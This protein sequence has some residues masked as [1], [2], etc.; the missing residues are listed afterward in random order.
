VP[1]SPEPMSDDD[2][3]PL[4]SALPPMSSVLDSPG[5]TALREAIGDAPAKERAR[6]VIDALR[7]ELSRGGAPADRASLLARASDAL[8]A[9]AARGSQRRLRPVLNATGVVLHTNLGR[10]PLSDAVLDEVRAASTGAC[11]LEFD[12]ER[13]AR[14]RRDDAVRGLLTEVT[15]AE[16]GLVVNNCA[17]AVLLACTAFGAGREVI[18]SRGELV[19]IGGGFRIPDVIASCGATLVEVGTTNRTRAEDYAR[20]ASPRTGAFLSVHPSNFALRGFT[21]RPT[22]ESLAEL[23]REREIPLLEDLGSGALLDLSA[24]GIEREPTVQEA[25]AGGS[26]V[27]MFSG[28]KLLGGPQAGILVGRARWIEPL[29]RHPLLRALRP[30]RLVLAALESVLARY[31]SG[32]AVSELPALRALVEPAE[33]VRERALSLHALVTSGPDGAS[34]TERWMLAVAPSIARVGGGTLPLAALPSHALTIAPRVPDASL[35]TLDR[36]LRVEGDP[37]LI[38]RTRDGAL[39]VDLRT[40]PARDLATLA[41]VLVRALATQHDAPREAPCDRTWVP[42]PDAGDGLSDD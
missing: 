41:G 1:E 19:E 27:V 22:R 39:W 29:R 11:A 34:V 23:A 8:A 38:A 15:G 30:G 17:A 14:G 7:A 10:A 21:A 16:D 37:P 26:D 40:I 25:V 2:P 13:G 28:D 4:R 9:L 6:A 5:A 36:A 31:A 35:R 3:R 42:D 18:V 20:A 24:H 12:L 33:S 32:R